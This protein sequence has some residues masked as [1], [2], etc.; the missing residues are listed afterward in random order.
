MKAI[1]AKQISLLIDLDQEADRREMLLYTCP[2]WRWLKKR[3][4]LRA[5]QNAA[6][7]AWRYRV[8][9]GLHV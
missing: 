8:D 7:S 5:W 9:L 2:D 6:A 1:T 3:R 4:L